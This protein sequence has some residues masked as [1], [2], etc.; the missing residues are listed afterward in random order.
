MKFTT[1][2]VPAFPGYLPKLLACVVVLL[3]RCAV[4]GQAPSTITLTGKV[5]L[6]NGSPDL[7]GTSIQIK[8]TKKGVTTDAAGSYTISAPRK[9]TLVFSHIGYKSEEW[10]ITD[11]TEVN[12]TLGLADNSL[13]QVVV[14]SYGKQRQRDITGSVTKVDA[15]A[16]QDVSATEF[17]QK[18]QSKVAGL[19]VGQT[20]G[21]P[22]QAMTFRIRGSASLSSGNQPLVVVD[23]QPIISDVGSGDVNLISPDEIESYSVLK[24]AAATA[25]YGSRAANGVIIITTKQAKMGR[26]SVAANVYYGLQS[27]PQRGRPDLMNAQ[28]FAT[29]MQGYYQDRITYE[30]WV[31]PLTGTATVPSDYA[32]PS[33]YGKGTDWYNSILRTAP[34][35][36]YSVSIS[37]GSEKVSSTT[38]FNYF[39]QQGVLV[40]TGIQ[41]YAFRS[42][43][44]YRPIDHVKIGLNIA[45]T[46]QIDHNTRGGAL[47]I[48]GNRQIVSGAD[49]SSPLI[50]PHAA[51]GSWNQ[52][53]SSYGMYALPNFLQQEQ[54]MNNNQTNLHMLGNA[55]LDIEIIKGLHAKT[56]INGDLYTQDFN[57]YYGT[58]Y[59]TFG[60]PP[61]RPN[62]SSSASNSSNNTYSWL[63]ENTLD[64][65][66]AFGQHSIDVLAGYSTQKWNQN[67]RSVN[68]TGF[69]NDAVPWISGATTT[70]GTTNNS[71]WTIASALAR[72]NYDF[73]KRYYVSATIRRD[74][75]SRFGEFKKYGTF[76]SVSAGWV[77]SDES[78]FPKSSTFSFL[79]VKGSYGLTGNNNIGN[80]T[81]VSQLTP[82]N[83]VFNGATTLGESI[84]V[85]GNKNLTWETSKQ[86]DVGLE[87]NFLNNRIT[88]AYDYY[89]KLTD[90]MLSTLQVP[91]ASGYSSITYNVG[92][93]RIWG[94][95]FQVSSRNM[96]GKFTWTT[97]FNISFNNNKVIKLVNG[98]PIGGVNRYS[99]YNRTAVGHHI[100]ELYGY[101]FQGVYMNQADF[102]KYPH[103]A[104]SA[105]GTARMK[106][107]NGDGK[108]DISDETFIGNPNPKY[109]YG[110]TNSFTY[111]NFD[112]AIIAGG[113]VGNKIMNINLQNLQN[114]DGIF[115]IDKDMQNRWRSVSNPGNGKVPRTLSNTTE[116]YRLSNTNWVFSG[117]YLSIRNISVGYT[118]PQR[119]LRYMKSVRV[120]ASVQNA[121]M[122]TKYPGQNPEV[123]DNKDAQTVAGLDNGSYPIPRTFMA[124]ANINF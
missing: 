12:I 112:F 84:T 69:A 49:I 85:L 90:G 105:V 79:K 19:Q 7:S 29:F 8:G 60:N 57:A 88:F 13:D 89:N 5:V 110:I 17:G 109:I 47:A 113:Q 118:L 115:N 98:T 104:T 87:A 18:L 102:D 16:V 76:P 106:D 26:T 124:G 59:G 114:L 21:M 71:S 34:I 22:G 3:L 51:D 41:R 93:F 66:R 27:V 72:V 14:V 75:S 33:Q 30:N 20:S 81:Q 45:P 42:N 35:E 38:S 67:N 6:G 121:F 92:T 54:I 63:N 83:Y 108:V 58:Q 78:F 120:Y 32:N 123:N 39:N 122:F 119:M 73:A 43:N 31:N 80:Y 86:T 1:F 56:T 74:G 15:S 40:N 55:Y 107:V 91:Y 101:V 53:T 25:L 36:N 11:Q 97:D 70:T 95:E 64:Y 2:T 77:V 10:R 28:Q 100:G 62:S 46:Y 23:G 9:A 117:D 65:A 61:P 82:T 94:H 48:N 111:K 4:Y 99:D 96:T 116:L 68:G 24:D 103:E 44:E 37:S 52:K 50:A